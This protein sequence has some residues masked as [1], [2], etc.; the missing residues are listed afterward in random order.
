MHAPSPFQVRPS[1]REWLAISGVWLV[2]G[3]SMVVWL[4]HSRNAELARESHS[5]ASRARI[6]NDNLL[7]QIESA[8]RPLADIQKFVTRPD[9]IRPANS[10]L[11]VL[12]GAALSGT[13]SLVQTDAQG[14][15]VAASRGELVG[16]NLSQR[17]YFQVARTTADPDVLHLAPTFT[18]ATGVASTG[19]LRSLR[20]PDGAFA[21]IV[22]ATFTPERFLTLMAAV[23]L[24]PEMHV[25]L[26]DTGG[27]SLAAA[28]AD[29]AGTGAPNG[30]D[31]SVGKFMASGKA[32][33][34]MAVAGAAGE[35][36]VVAVHRVVAP[37][38]RMD[39]PLFVLVSEPVA[40]I[41][42]RW[43][44]QA[45][46]A[47][48]WFAAFTL[49]TGLALAWY[50]R[51]RAA[52]DAAFAVQ[53]RALQQSEMRFR[54]L[55][56]LSTDWYWEQ[57]EELRFVRFDG[58]EALSSRHRLH[59]H[60]GKA[61][62]EFEASN[63]TD[64]LWARHR[65]VLAARQPFRE[66]ILA[67]PGTHGQ[68]LVWA[69]I[70]GEPIFDDHGSFKGYRG[71]GRD[72][73]AEMTAKNA[74]ER[75]EQR[76]QLMLRG[77]DDG[78]WDVDLET[79]RTLHLSQRW[80]D[81]VGWDAPPPGLRAS[82]WRELW[83]PDDAE[84]MQ[85]AMQ[86]ALG[87]DADGYNFDLRLRHRSGHYI[88]VNTRAVIVRNPAGRAI[89][90]AGVTTD[91]SER[92]RIEAD[93]EALAQAKLAQ[94]TRAL[95]LAATQQAREVA[96]AHAQ[97]LSVLLTERDCSIAQRDEL[98]GLLAHEIRQPLHNASA[99]LQGASMALAGA[100]IS[101]LTAAERL[102]RAQ[103]VMDQIIDT[104]NNSLAAS[105]LM[106]NPVGLSQ[107][108]FDLDVLLDLALAD[109]GPNVRHRVTARCL[110]GARTAE[111]NV[112]LMR[113]LLRNLLV[114]A[115]NYSPPHS[116]VELTVMVDDAPLSLVIEV[117]DSGPGI[118][119]A[120]LPTLFDRGTRGVASNTVTGAGLGL[121]VVARVA[122]LHRGKVEVVP[123]Q[124]CGTVFRVILPQG[125]LP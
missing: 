107:Q 41:L 25:A 58:G 33:D 103:A 55:T 112:A 124:P 69:A 62:W 73:T 95:E 43:R 35:R 45:Q 81:L 114:N 37:Q 29:A 8:N 40:G 85:A 96:E 110:N 9:G 75:S 68:G 122:T 34:V 36:R 97:S 20:G 92:A 104:V 6:L 7:R 100:D 108:E 54:D 64:E 115:L 80:C 79:D 99:A 86:S 42:A 72:I 65:A 31:A 14:T 51:R 23:R 39:R 61:R 117:A 24:T 63:M 22:G 50:Q 27:V 82:F 21:G 120:L 17:A 88:P 121:Y 84:R 93:R 46:W 111:F 18:G 94:S 5:L 123:R 53:H 30:G 3:L 87:S 118:S 77:S 38:L 89:R 56:R 102:D 67:R 57:D 26:L 106:A 49:G 70:S 28:P 44:P 125:N 47:S 76:L 52:R 1:R 83:H 74:L 90:I 32:S 19:L 119:D 105:T 60:L 10:E 116:T 16:T 59:E 113:Q 91:L 98:L 66:L 12:L 101:R 13:R 2:I 71:T 4:W 15:V 109:L 78:S 48:A 11:L